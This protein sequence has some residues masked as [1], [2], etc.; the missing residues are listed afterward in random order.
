MR[1]DRYF[2]VLNAVWRHWIVHR[3]RY[4]PTIP[5]SCAQRRLASLDCSPEGVGAR[6]STGG[7]L[8]AVWHHWI[9]HCS[10]IGR[11]RQVTRVL[12][13]VWRHW[14]V[15]DPLCST[16]HRSLL[17]STPFGVIGLFTQR[18]GRRIR[19]GERVLNAVWRHWIV[20]VPLAV[21]GES[22]LIVLN[23]VWRHWIVHTGPDAGPA[24]L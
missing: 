14:I 7:V 6:H 16:T 4:R 5:K 19:G 3:R 18:P 9:V 24:P 15:H 17:C 21:L 20:H 1:A 10:R 8:N 22:C 11:N 23:A 2:R 13:A 12:N